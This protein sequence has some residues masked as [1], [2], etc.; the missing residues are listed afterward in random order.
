MLAYA[1]R[2]SDKTWLADSL[3]PARYFV[4]LFLWMEKKKK[5]MFFWGDYFCKKSEEII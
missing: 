1:S 5:I 2:E 3:D 4:F